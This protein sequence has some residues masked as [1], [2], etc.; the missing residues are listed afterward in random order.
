MKVFLPSVHLVSTQTIH[1]VCNNLNVEKIESGSVNKCGQSKGMDN[2]SDKDRVKVTEMSR[3]HNY[4]SGLCEIAELFHFTN[5]LDFI[6]EGI[7]IPEKTSEFFYPCAMTLQVRYI[8]GML[9]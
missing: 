3:N 8:L 7:L 1:E 4:R 6:T 5:N 9:Y 2:P